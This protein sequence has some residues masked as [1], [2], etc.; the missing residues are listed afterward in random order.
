MVLDHFHR[1]LTP[2]SEIQ[3]CPENVRRSPVL[4]E[5]P[6]ALVAHVLGEDSLEGAETAGGV[7]VAHDADYNHGRSLH[8]GHSLHHFLLVDLCV[9]MKTLTSSYANC[10][11]LYS[12]D[13]IGCPQDSTFSKGV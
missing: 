6:L 7:D 4:V 9:E 8:D 10:L 3:K 5:A 1:R 2:A 12:A 13:S 11:T